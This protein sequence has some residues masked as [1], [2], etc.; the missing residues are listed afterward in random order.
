MF[1]DGSCGSVNTLSLGSTATA[2][3]QK[4]GT[5]HTF[6]R[7]EKD[8]GLFKADRDLGPSVPPPPP[9]MK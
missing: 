1:S 5:S 4:S 9:V 7:T 2:E 3:A 8:Q 6:F